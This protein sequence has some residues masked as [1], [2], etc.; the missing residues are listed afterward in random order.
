MKRSAATIECKRL[1]V[2]SGVCRKCYT[3]LQHHV[4]ALA[5]VEQLNDCSKVTF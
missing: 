4:C 2:Q 3:V 1:F 5:A